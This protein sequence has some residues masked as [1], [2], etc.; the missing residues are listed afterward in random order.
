[1][2]PPQTTVRV[3]LL[4]HDTADTELIENE[5]KN[6]GIPVTLLCLGTREEFLAALRKKP[7]DL[8]LS[9]YVLSSY[10]GLVA[11]ADAQKIC[12]NLPFIFVSREIHEQSVI[13][14]L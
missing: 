3:L 5:L 4:E 2:N 13:D 9:D 8:I 1:M 14:T 6:S 12:P 7:P 11:M 10:S